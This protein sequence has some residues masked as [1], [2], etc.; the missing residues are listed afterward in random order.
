MPHPSL[1]ESTLGTPDD[2]KDTKGVHSGEAVPFPSSPSA[3]VVVW[4]PREEG[5]GKP[6]PPRLES[7]RLT[8]SL[9]VSLRRHFS[10][11]IT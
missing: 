1:P 5:G 11:Y 7:A 9:H 6:L 4:H 8:I 2:E 10:H 3:S